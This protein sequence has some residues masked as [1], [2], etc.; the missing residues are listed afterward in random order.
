[1][2][3]IICRHLLAIKVRE[4]RPDFVAANYSFVNTNLISCTVQGA[5]EYEWKSF[6]V[7]DIKNILVKINFEEFMSSETSRQA[8]QLQCT[9][10]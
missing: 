1:M 7:I 10:K 2:I 4:T 8:F 3:V 5:M 9:V 6:E